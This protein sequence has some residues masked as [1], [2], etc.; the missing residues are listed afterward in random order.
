MAVWVCKISDLA[1]NNF[2]KARLVVG[3]YSPSNGLIPTCSLCNL[4]FTITKILVSEVYSP[5]VITCSRTGPAWAWSGSLAPTN[6][7]HDLAILRYIF[8]HF[9]DFLR[10]SLATNSLPSVSGAVKRKHKTFSCVIT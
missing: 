7:I 2:C 9:Y 10:L 3:C 8:A 5:P 4:F 1:A 6:S